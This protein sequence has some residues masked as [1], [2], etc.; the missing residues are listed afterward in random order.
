MKHLIFY[1]KN[2]IYTEG[3]L[4]KNKVIIDIL[5]RYQKKEKNYLIDALKSNKKNQ[6]KYKNIEL[7]NEKYKDDDIDDDNIPDII[8]IFDLYENYNT[9]DMYYDNNKEYSPDSL[10]LYCYETKNKILIDII[11]DLEKQN[12]YKKY[13]YD[14][15]FEDYVHMSY[16]ETKNNKIDKYI[17][18]L[19]T[20]LY[21][22]KDVIFNLNY[23]F[24]NLS[25]KTTYYNIYKKKYE[26]FLYEED[27]YNDEFLFLC[28]DYNNYN[29]YIQDLINN[30]KD[31]NEI[32]KYNKMF[33]TNPNDLILSY[34]IDLSVDYE[35]KKEI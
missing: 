4:T 29:K 2:T 13:E 18:I 27:N 23:K 8:K 30:S 35:N 6:Q 22:F 16:Y 31:L 33:I 9:Y 26:D 12:L 21:D 1:R 20:Y 7:L 17:S 14:E 11:L 32:K 28:I 34:E 5:K 24:I 15:S 19:N 10:N 25:D 3:F